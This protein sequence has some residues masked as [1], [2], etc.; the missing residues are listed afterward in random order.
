MKKSAAR[1]I[2]VPPPEGDAPL[3][4]LS[5]AGIAMAGS[6]D[7]RTI[8]RKTAET[9]SRLLRT[10]AV[11]VL[12]T[13]RAS[14]NSLPLWH[15]STPAAENLS[16][17]LRSR[18]RERLSLVA[19][20]H[21]DAEAVLAEELREARQSAFPLR[22]QDELL[23]VVFFRS[24]ARETPERGKLLSILAQHAAT[25]LRNIH[26]N[27]ER[28]HFERLSAVGRMIGTI[29]HDL[30]S[31]LTALRG[32]AGMLATL[33]L[34][35]H[36]RREYG[37]WMLDECDR[38]GHMVSELLEFTRGGRAALALEW[39]RIGDCLGGFAERLGRHYAERGIRVELSPS[40][41]R[42][43]YVD[44]ARLER[45]L[46]NV[47][48]NGC[49]A[50]PGGGILRLRTE[51]RGD[52]VAIS[53]EDEGGGIPEAIRHRVFEPF[54]SYGKS[55]GV[56]LGMVTAQKI[57]EEHGG[58]IE[59]ESRDD[60]GTLVRFLLPLA[61]PGERESVEASVATRRS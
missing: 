4:I 15:P 17:S 1:S 11:E 8:L 52:E 24:E 14:I 36:E 45:A 56:G 12:Y 6:F 23:G 31:P 22:Y 34:E 41:A 47:A 53:V 32:Y 16:E 57:A 39:V 13:G 29:V 44:R 51:L 21:G 55:E 59:I 48:V 25:A 18:L 9:A 26:L 7:I 61:G 58:R 46:W 54:F 19:E 28:I 30:K 40:Y 38:L 42:E 27:Q 35:D 37:R 50:M 33:P 49:Q 5:D 10:P 60:R 43:V 3:E 20:S 2:P